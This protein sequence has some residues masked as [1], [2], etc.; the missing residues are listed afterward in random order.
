MSEPTPTSRRTRRERAVQ[1]DAERPV[2]TS[3]VVLAAVCTGIA[4]LPFLA[5]YAVLFVAHALHPIGPPDI[6]NTR[7]GELVAGVVAFVAFALLAAAVLS[8]LNQR[9][10]W[11]FVLLELATLV[12]TVLFLGDETTGGPAISWLLAAT[13]V[14]AVVLGL[15][16]AS[17]RHVGSPVGR[18]RTK[19]NAPT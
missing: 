10:R 19:V 12:T 7:T 14:A 9:R 3:P 18:G 16:P 11:P 17:A 5:V 8:Y 6:T 13:S 1:R 4:P 15:L 2:E